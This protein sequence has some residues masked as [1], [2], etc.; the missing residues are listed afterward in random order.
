MYT[1][2]F[3][4]FLKITDLRTYV[5]MLIVS[6]NKIGIT[7]VDMFLLFP[8]LNFKIKKITSIYRTYIRM[9]LIDTRL[10]EI[11]NNGNPQ[12]DT[13]HNNTISL[14]FVNNNK[15]D[16]HHRKRIMMYNNNGCGGV[17]DNIELCSVG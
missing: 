17:V 1:P 4:L 15:L 11:G 2:V 16:H 5:R 3:F 9:S 12:C 14:S 13:R 10:I 8:P 7:H 6:N